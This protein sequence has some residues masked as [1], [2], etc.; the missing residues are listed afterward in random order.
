M[1]GSACAS[2]ACSA[3]LNYNLSV[4][5][6]IR[7]CQQKHKFMNAMTYG[8]LKYVLLVATG[9]TSMTVLAIPVSN[10]DGMQA[11]R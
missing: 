6:A 4:Q 3:A 5:V 10:P 11:L 8:R 9:G 1:H 7:E 2:L